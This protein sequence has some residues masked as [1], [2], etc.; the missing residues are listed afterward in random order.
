[1]W[2]RDQ[3]AQP[4]AAQPPNPGAPPSLARSS[5]TPVEP[6]QPPR[7]SDP[8]LANIGRS[9]VIRGDLRGSEDLVIEGQVDG[10]IEL[11][12]NTLTIGP[13]GRVKAEVSARTVIVLGTVN[14]QITTSNKVDLREGGHV[15]GDIASPRVAIADGATF[16]GSV[17]MKPKATNGLQPGSAAANTAPKTKSD[18]TSV[19]EVQPLVAAPAL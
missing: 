15:D 7:R 11:K 1:M 3:A 13:H 10:T 9:V 18:T 5:D 6:A 16:C 2:K 14:G 4:S 17:D 19:G 8:P 12:D